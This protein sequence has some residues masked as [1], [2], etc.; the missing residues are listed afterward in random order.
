MRAIQ[1]R[2][3]EAFPAHAQERVYGFP[4]ASSMKPTRIAVPEG[5]INQIPGECT[6]S[7]DIRLTPFYHVR[8]ASRTCDA[9][10]VTSGE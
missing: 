8:P 4:S 6:I 1:R 2:F 3:Y 7:G 9:G 5:S 10:R